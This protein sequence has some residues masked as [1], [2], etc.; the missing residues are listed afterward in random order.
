MTSPEELA[1]LGDEIYEQSVLPRTGP[2]DQ[3]KF[4]AIDVISGDYDI[5]RDE[6]LATDRLRA[7]H[8]A[9][10]IWMRRIGSRH[11]HRFGSRPRPTAA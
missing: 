9:A 8:P 2:G 10:Q 5:D 11:T 6:L 4:V 7:R 1:R 3:G